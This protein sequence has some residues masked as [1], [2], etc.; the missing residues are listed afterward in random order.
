MDEIGYNRR[1]Q[2][3]RVT[4]QDDGFSS[5]GLWGDYGRAQRA[6]KKDM[7]DAERWRAGQV[8]AT[9]TAR[10]VVPYSRFS[11]GINPA[12]RLVCNGVEYDIFGVKEIGLRE[13]LEFTAGARAD[14]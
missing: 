6:S 4:L 7:S 11:A 9:V 12:D 8:S 3:R 5:S 13:G 1:V 14:K 2:F 10:F